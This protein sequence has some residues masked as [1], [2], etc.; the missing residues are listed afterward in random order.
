MNK[1]ATAICGVVL[2][3]AV[4]VTSAFADV[5]LGSGYNS[6]K[7]S[8]KATSK[9]MCKD[10][11]NFSA[12]AT[13]SVKVD[14]KEMVSANSDIK[15]DI[16]NQKNEES[17]TSTDNGKS[18]THYSY[19]DKDKSIYYSE[20][21]DMYYVYERTRDYSDGS[22][23]TDP[24]DEP[25]MADVEKI[26]DAV[27]GNLK[28]TVQV[29]EKDGKV[30]YSANI[31]ETQIPA[32]ANAVTSYAVKYG[33]MSDR[34]I[35]EYHLPKITSDV[36][37]KEATGRAIAS[38]DG[39]LEDGTGK[40]T[41][42]GKDEN[43]VEHEFTA[44]LALSISNVNSTVVNEPNLDGKNVEYTKDTGSYNGMSEK[45]IGTYK[46][47]ILS[48]NRND[49]EKIGERTLVITSVNEGSV[50][51]T[52]SE[53]YTDGG[54]HNPLSFDFTA[55]FGETGDFRFTYTDAEGNQQ[56]GILYPTGRNNQ[57][58][59]MELNVEFSEDGYSRYYNDDTFDG[60][61]IREF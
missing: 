29:E 61:F 46:N 26:F 53:T 39:V 1:K 22:F 41:L 25:Q 44:E 13:I 27:I 59:Y 19:Y 56:N 54:E 38:Q 8:I 32:L 51:G 21:E 35:E 34:Q 5:M 50:T 18:F 2:G 23:L 58:M 30:L 52:Y 45:H 24:F 15:M 14:G 57:N 48:D 55:D 40:M 20:D 60:D 37:V 47:V 9:T 43:G 12:N 28:D 10:V 49:F 6:L 36:Y 42:V 31:S 17:T 3:A 11:D 33:I 16:A 7:D 4:F